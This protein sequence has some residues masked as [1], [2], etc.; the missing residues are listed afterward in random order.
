[1]AAAPGSGADGRTGLRNLRLKVIHFLN[2][3]VAVDMVHSF[4]HDDGTNG[5]G[6]GLGREAGGPF[7]KLLSTAEH[8]TTHWWC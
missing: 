2:I 3:G 7:Y 6:N 8:S 1:M 5:L 4:C